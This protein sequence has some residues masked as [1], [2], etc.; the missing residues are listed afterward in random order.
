MTKFLNNNY[1]SI[2]MIL[3]LMFSRLIPHPPNFTPIISLAL[4]SGY[5]FRNISVSLTVLF[6]T[7]LITDFFIGFYLNMIFV[8]I[9]ISIIC[10]FSFKKIKKINYKNLYIYSVIGS[11][12]FFIITNFG[13]WLLSDMYVKN[14]NGLFSCYFLALP[15]FTNTLISTL[16]FS[17]LSLYFLRLS[18]AKQNKLKI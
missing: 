1:F 15:F 17:Y 4:M 10:F 16:F 6:I 11:L 7:M 13:V 3:I 18:S 14:L 2:C 9:A 5:V 12:S 8:Y